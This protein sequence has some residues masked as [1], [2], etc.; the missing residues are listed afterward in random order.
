MER[1]CL[2]FF[3]QRTRDETLELFNIKQKP[4]YIEFTIQNPGKNEFGH[5]CVTLRIYISKFVTDDH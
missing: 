2:E 1:E 4:N 5:T 3:K